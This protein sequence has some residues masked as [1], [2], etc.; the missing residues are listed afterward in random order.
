MKMDSRKATIKYFGFGT[1]RDLEMMQHMIGRENINGEHGR[2]IG[3][4][5]TIQK[6]DQFRTKM[7][8]TSPNPKMSAR[9]IIMKAWGAKFEMFT[10]R[11][12]PTG[13]IYGT[14]WDITPEELELVKNWE[15]VDFG[16]Q[17]EA[18]GIALTDTGELVEVIIQS[19]LKPA[20]IDR[21]IKGDDYEP[22]IW[23]KESL[24]KK[25]DQVRLNFLG[26]KKKSTRQ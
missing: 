23:D 18:R 20:E 19:F 9:D 10:S 5:L 12:N 11:P 14:I 26:M 16:C 7:P 21:V 15:M 6:A 2:L 13:I 25:A 8:A 22:Y 1:N 17:E 4:E 24:L 3:Y